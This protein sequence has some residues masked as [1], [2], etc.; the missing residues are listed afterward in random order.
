MGTWG[1]GIFSDD[2]ARD[3]RDAWRDALMD[4]LDDATATKRV[5]EE[6]HAAFDDE[7]DAVVAWLALAAAQHETGRLQLLVRDRALAIIDA[8]GDLDSWRNESAAFRRAR[9]KALATLAEKLCGPQP[10]PKTPKRPKPR[11]S[12]LE[13]GD[14]VH[15]R[16]EREEGLFVVVG[17]AETSLGTE[18]VLAE[19]LWEGGRVPDV[20]TLKRLP[21]LHEEEPIS[22]FLNE[23]T[24]PVQHFWQVDC[25]SRGKR[26]L[27]N[28]GSVVAKGVLRADAAD[29]LRDQ[30]RGFADGPSVS[31]GGWDT[32]AAFMGGP[33][34]TR[35]VETTRRI[36]GI[37]GH[38]TTQ[39][40]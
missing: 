12:P 19:L 7:D 29:H 10:A 31:G 35:L 5:L 1:P 11:V 2:V 6:L 24:R 4:G 32:L 18:P 23:I 21:L 26:A 38:S 14:V 39:R 36:H 37:Q 28:F 40:L 20:E 9:E 8:G 30:S 17:I 3:V 15:V 25:P 16:G 27:S 22:S 33:W 34:H 13:I